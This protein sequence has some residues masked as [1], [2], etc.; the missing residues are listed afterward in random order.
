V[1]LGFLISVVVALAIVGLVLWVL[2][3]IP[4]DATIARIIRVVIV[5]V[6]CIWLLYLLVGLL[7]TGPSI[8]PPLRR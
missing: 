3:Q 7:G 8:L 1:Q 2:Q 6:V 4:M 5:V